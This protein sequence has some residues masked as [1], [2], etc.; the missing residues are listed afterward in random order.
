MSG[1]IIYAKRNSKDKYGYG[2]D[3]TFRPLDAQGFRVNTLAQAMVYTE[4]SDAEYILS[5]AKRDDDVT[6]EIRP[7]PKT[8]KTVKK[9]EIFNS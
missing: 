6:Y 3:R 9:S 2:P 7:V 5:K 4:K 8:K 1:F